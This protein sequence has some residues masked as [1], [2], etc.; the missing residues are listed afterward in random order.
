MRCMLRLSVALK[1]W[2]LLAVV[3]V[4][5]APATQPAPKTS[6]AKSDV[7]PL[8]T[9]VHG[10]LPIVISSPHGGR[11]AIPDVPERKGRDG[12]YRFVAENDANSGELA[13]KLVAEIEKR[14]GK[15]PYYVRAQFQRRY[16]DANRDAED[17]FESPLAKPHY[18]AY[19]T[20]LEEACREIQKKWHGGLLLDIHGQS[21]YPDNVLRG[22]QNG[23]TV[24]RLVERR[25]AEALIGESSIFGRLGK[26]GYNVLPKT[27][28]TDKET[29]R[30]TGGYTVKTYGSHNAGGIDAVQVEFGRNYRVPMSA[31]EESATSLAEVVYD[32]AVEYLPAA[33]DSTKSSEA[34]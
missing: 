24:T 23:L 30:Y 34:Q 6:K 28:T 13:D 31:A 18:A 32:Y 10:E 25:G 26:A 22:T 33:I 15:K 3:A 29:E 4:A 8:V 14:F 5:Q 16:C 12:I 17:A 9:I 1:V 19:H 21:S 7:K 20:A 27:D 2:L 11:E